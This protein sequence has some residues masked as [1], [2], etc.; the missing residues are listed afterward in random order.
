MTSLV[1][2]MLLLLLSRFSRVRLCTTDPIDVDDSTPG[3]PI[4]GLLQARI[5]MQE[6]EKWTSNIIFW[7]LNTTVIWIKWLIPGSRT[8]HIQYETRTEYKESFYFF[9]CYYFFYCSGFCYTLKW[10]SHG[11]NHF[12]TNRVMYKGDKS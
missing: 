4:P 11:K 1:T 10:N 3:S 7:S 9:N 2:L 5:L 8:K 12:K 6:S